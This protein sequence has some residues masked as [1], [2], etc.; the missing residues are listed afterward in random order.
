MTAGP[1][2]WYVRG[3]LATGN[4]YSP[5]TMLDHRFLDLIQSIDLSQRTKSTLEIIDKCS[6]SERFGP[7]CSNTRSKMDIV[8]DQGFLVSR[9]CEI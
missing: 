5:D 4:F 9:I 1:F 8:I 7:V 3:L 2:L 6:R